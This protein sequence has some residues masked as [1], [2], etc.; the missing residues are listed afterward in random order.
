M[1]FTVSEENVMSNL[2]YV[3][4]KGSERMENM[5]TNTTNLIRAVKQ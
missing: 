2:E 3:F 1:F 4:Y 5:S